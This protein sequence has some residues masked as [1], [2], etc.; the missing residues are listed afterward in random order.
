MVKSAAVSSQLVRVD[1]SPP[2]YV[3]V[4]GAPKIERRAILT[5]GEGTEWQMSGVVGIGRDGSCLGVSN[6][7][8]SHIDAPYHLISD[9]AYLDEID[10]RHYL[11]SWTRVVDLTG[12]T[13]E[14]RETVEAVDYHSRIDVDD[15]PDALDG[16]D[17][18]LFVT[19]F[20]A[21]IERGYPMKPGAESHYPN[22]TREAAERIAAVESLRL[23]AIDSPSFDKPE[24]RA[25]AHRVLLGRRPAPILLLETLTCEPL[26]RA[27]EPLPREVLL[28]VE[29]LRAFGEHADGALAS[30]YAYAPGDITPEDFRQ[31][32]EL[33]RNAR[34]VGS[35]KG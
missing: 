12:S 22:V 30:V 13:P 31:F 33:I 2:E 19:G 23:V 20:G 32:V 28:T 4:P 1:L 9:G 15:L 25:I 6:H 7:T 11:A 21:L 26:R 17:A 14:R 34:V 29:P 10:P 18:L 5:R 27:L 35:Q 16:Y 3:H 8:W 24:T